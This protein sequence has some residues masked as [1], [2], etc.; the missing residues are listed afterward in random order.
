M[1]A[2]PERE[3]LAAVRDDTA[4]DDAARGTTP[5]V[6]R[7]PVFTGLR[8]TTFVRVDAADARLRTFCVALSVRDELPDFWRF[9]VVDIF[10][11]V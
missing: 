2:V 7:A 9:D 6:V 8:S 11:E 3:T 10:V 4:F 5:V 1:V